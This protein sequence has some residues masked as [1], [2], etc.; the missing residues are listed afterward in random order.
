MRINRLPYNAW[1]FY[2]KSLR[3][4]YPRIFVWQLR[5]RRS[6][7]HSEQTDYQGFL[8]ACKIKGW[9]PNLQSFRINKEIEMLCII[10]FSHR[11]RSLS[12]FSGRSLA[13]P[14]AM[15]PSDENSLTVAV[16]VG[17]GV[18]NFFASLQSAT[19]AGR[20]F[21]LSWYLLDVDSFRVLHLTHPCAPY[22]STVLFEASQWWWWLRGFIYI[23]ELNIL[24]KD[25]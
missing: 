25:Q 8:K 2:K 14:W 15:L 10:L 22:I 3:L 12:R 4:L 19:F 6:R 13:R 1:I 16:E 7:S 18:R 9:S 20:S 11:I 23:L 17:G 24:V 5:L 21:E